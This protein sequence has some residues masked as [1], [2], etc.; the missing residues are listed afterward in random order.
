VKEN[1][2][3]S[4]TLCQFHCGVPDE[5]AAPM[6]RPATIIVSK[7]ISP[8]NKLSNC[9]IRFSCVIN[10]MISLSAVFIRR[11]VCQ[12]ELKNK[13]AFQKSVI[14]KDTTFKTKSWYT[15]VALM[16]E[17][18]RSVQCGV[19]YSS[20]QYSNQVQRSVVLMLHN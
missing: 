20:N 6:C 17:L 2:G 18:L 1:L 13:H 12:Y 7:R 14:I 11:S 16:V 15:T 9:L 19:S 8:T 10:N 5:C 4:T 3:R